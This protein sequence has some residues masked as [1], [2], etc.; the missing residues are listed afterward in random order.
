MLTTMIMDRVM[1]AITGITRII[2]TLMTT[3]SIRATTITSMLIAMSMRI[4][5]ARITVT[6]RNRLKN[7]PALNISVPCIQK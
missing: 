3:N 5:R 4:I 6:N 2:N 7:N 1:S